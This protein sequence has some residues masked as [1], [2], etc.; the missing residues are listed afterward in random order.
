MIPKYFLNAQI[1]I[2]KQSKVYNVQLHLTEDS[3]SINLY[4][5][6]VCQT[7]KKNSK[8]SLDH[9]ENLNYSQ[10]ISTMQTMFSVKNVIKVETS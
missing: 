1:N 8:T 5:I 9:K 10:I 4:Q 2:S 6:S 7:L 3:P